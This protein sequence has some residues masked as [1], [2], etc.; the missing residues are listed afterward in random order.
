MKVFVNRLSM[1]LTALA[2]ALL[3]AQAAPPAAPPAVLTIYRET[4]KP[5]KGAAHDQN[6]E[7]WA[8]TLEAAKPPNGYL[9]ASAMSGSP[10]NWY[11]SLFDNWAALEAANKKTEASPAQLAI[12][13][14]F[15]AMEGDLISDGRQM[16][17][18]ARTDLDYGRADLATSRYF[19]VTRISVRPGHNAEFEENRKMVKAAHERA[20][21]GDSFSVWQASSGAPAGTYYIFAARK[22]LSELDEG[23]AMHSTPAYLAALGGAD[24]QKKMADN[25]TASVLS[26]QGD[27]FA[28]A[29]QQSI[30]PP[31]WVTADP[32]YWRKKAPAPRTP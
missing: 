31:E 25:T 12:G 8:R 23:S 3:G 32:G 13:K 26:S 9:A 1:V 15:S 10:E 14:R 5:G 4:V 6:E 22:S 27:L 29:P 11:M 18:T 16:I 19:S 7:A 21:L 28:F 2:P 20:G 30:P 24:G 17:L